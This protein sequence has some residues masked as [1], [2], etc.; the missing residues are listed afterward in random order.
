MLKVEMAPART[1]TGS[2]LYISRVV[3]VE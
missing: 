2:I 3:N 1:Y